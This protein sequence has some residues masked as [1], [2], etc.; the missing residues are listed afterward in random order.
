MCL[1]WEALCVFVGDEEYLGMGGALK[2][3]VRS[4]SVFALPHNS[5]SGQRDS[6]VLSACLAGASQSCHLIAL[7]LF[8]CECWRT[9]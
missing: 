4:I 8:V 1:F 2:R 3:D 9:V 7:P 6:V 5:F